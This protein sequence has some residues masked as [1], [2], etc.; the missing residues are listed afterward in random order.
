MKQN[1]YD[2]AMDILSSGARLLLEAGQGG[3][4]GDLCLFLLEVY[5][6]AELTPDAASKARLLALLR[7][8][9]AG[10]PTRKRF[11]NEML[12]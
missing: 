8:F 10:E 4:G 2:A 1:N 6:K 11:V 12:S 7:S 9:P 5:G 3:S